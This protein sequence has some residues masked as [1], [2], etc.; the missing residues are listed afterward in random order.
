M[1]TSPHLFE[2]YEMDTADAPCRYELPDHTLCGEPKSAHA[3][4]R[5]INPATGRPHGAVLADKSQRMAQQMSGWLGASVLVNTP[6][7]PEG[8]DKCSYELESWCRDARDLLFAFAAILDVMRRDEA[9][10][11]GD[12]A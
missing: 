1:S 7:Y 11:A 8:G 3:A 10:E 5:G 6:L 9:N 12:D 4:G 2:R